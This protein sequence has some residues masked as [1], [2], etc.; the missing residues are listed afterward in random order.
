MLNV[1]T[2]IRVCFIAQQFIS[3]TLLT[4]CLGLASMSAY[5]EDLDTANTITLIPLPEA[6]LPES[7]LNFVV[8]RESTPADPRV[9]RIAELLRT[10]I[11]NF[12]SNPTMYA[13]RAQQKSSVAPLQAM[14]QTSTSVTPTARSYGHKKSL[15]NQLISSGI[16][17]LKSLVVQNSGAIQTPVQV[18]DRLEV[19]TRPIGTPRQIKV[20]EKQGLQGVT[21]S[22][23]YTAAAAGNRDEQVVQAFLNSYRTYLR[24]DDPENELQLYRKESDE[25]NQRHFRFNQ[26]YRNLPVWPADLIVH[27][28]ADGNVDS[29]NGAFIPTPRKV[30]TKPLVSSTEA[31]TAARTY[32][33]G[34]EEAEAGRPELIIYG[35]L[36]GPARLAWKLDLNVALGAHWIVVVDALDGT[37]LTAFNNIQ[38]DNVA[39]SG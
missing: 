27:L 25:L 13:P 39:G 37:I 30:A 23:A 4:L 14:P 32:I 22:T 35:P 7:S 36:D 24:L 38:Y 1:N 12:Q 10:H 16:Q 11:R 29:L 5:S 8:D 34:S 28:N 2:L 19:R 6:P 26:R 3:C 9:A 21:P 17:G 33:P 31:V 20:R 18:E 15:P